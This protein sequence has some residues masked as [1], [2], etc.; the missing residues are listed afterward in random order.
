MLN[1]TAQRL[2]YYY[3]LHFPPCLR[4]FAF[5]RCGRCFCHSKQRITLSATTLV[6]Y[7]IECNTYYTMLC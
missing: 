2:D 4:F 3:H 1:E 7:E 6:Y 5:V